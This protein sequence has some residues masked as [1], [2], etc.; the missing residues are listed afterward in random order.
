MGNDDPIKKIIEGQ[1]LTREEAEGLMNMLV[2][3]GSSDIK[4]AAFLTGL[5]FKGATTDEIIGFSDSLR[6]QAVADRIPGVTDIVGTGG[7]GKNTINVSTASSITAS[8]L[9]I[10]VVKHGNVGITSKHGSADFM[11]FLGYDFQRGLEN[12]VDTLGK[13][14]FLY[15]FAPMLNP[16]FARFSDVRKKLGHRTIFNIMGPI[17]NPFDPDFLVIGTADEGTSGSYAHVLRGRNKRGYV[18]HS[19]DGLDEISPSEPTNG[20]L[21]DGEVTEI[22]VRPREI[23]GKEI[24]LSEVTVQDPEECFIRTAKGLMGLD[25]SASAFIALNTAPALVLNHMAESLTEGYSIAL[26]AINSGKAEKQIGLLTQ[27]RFQL[28]EIQR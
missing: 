7:D 8:S 11:K 9:G 26:D 13:D 1:S 28:N 21:V 27:G 25:E 5:H 2:S 15:A 12:P 23:T 16:S 14:H 3:D 10:P 17:T 18:L 24:S 4:K 20:F 19:S 6:K 22:V